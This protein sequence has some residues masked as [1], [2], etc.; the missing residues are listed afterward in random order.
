MQRYEV[1]REKWVLS[2]KDSELEGQCNLIALFML[3]NVY[4][5]FIRRSFHTCLLVILV[6]NSKY[7]SSLLFCKRDLGFVV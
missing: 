7:F 6:K 3:K 1:N 2:I 4:E 5:R